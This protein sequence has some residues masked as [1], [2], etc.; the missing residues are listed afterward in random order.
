VSG[1]RLPSSLC[2]LLAVSLLAAG[3][4]APPAVAPL[5]QAHSHNDYE[6]ARPLLD[7]L[8]QGFCSVEADVFLSG[9]K[10]LVGHTVFGLRAGRTLEALYLDPLRQRVKDNGGRV[11][12]KGPT[13]FLLIDVKTDARTTWAAL[14]KV[15]ARYSDILS[16]TTERGFRENAVTV[17]ISGNRDREAIAAQEVRYAAIDGRL[18]DL[19][20]DAP[21]QL[22]PWVSASWG[23]VFAWRGAGKM[24]KP[25]RAKLRDLVARAHRRSGWCGS[26]GRRTP[27]RRGASCS[28][29]RWT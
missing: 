2:A 27:G 7:A 10:L 21:A 14:A 18:S 5:R 3:P 4:G 23:S 20:S 11:Y 1:R 8:E 13:V 15:L 29:P 17:V 25:E 9:G 26:G 6:H 16:V 22:V 19:G 12:P 28:R 24:P